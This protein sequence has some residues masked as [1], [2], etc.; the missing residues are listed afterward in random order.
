MKIAKV[1]E[2][3]K[4]V[5]AIFRCPICKSEMRFVNRASL[6]CANRHCFDL[7]KYGYINFL[8]KQVK[9]PYNKELFESRRRVFTAG[10][11]DKIIDTLEEIISEQ[12]TDKGIRILDAGCGEGFFT[13]QLEKTTVKRHIFA[14]DIEKE[15]ILLASR[16][17]AS[18]KFFVGDLANIPLQNRVID[19]ILNIFSP[20]SYEEF[21]RVLTGDGIVIKVVPNKNYLIELREGA[22][23]QLSNSGYSNEQVVKLFKEKMNVIEGKRLSYTLPVSQAQ[24]VDFVAMTPM[25]FG[26]DKG[27]VEIDAITQITID[28]DVLVGSFSKV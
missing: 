23:A 17:A 18:T 6:I 9:T 10:F 16:Q 14:V 28:V 25:M 2:N 8:Q 3:F 15:A 20:A 21:G 12:T 4:A 7:S 11:Y 5:E 13:T 1:Y 22:K 27:K 26:V 24:L 19:V